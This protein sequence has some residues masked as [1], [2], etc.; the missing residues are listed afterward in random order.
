MVGLMSGGLVALE[1]IASKV[2]QFS[3][4]LHL[5]PVL[6]FLKS[7]LKFQKRLHFSA[8][9]VSNIVIQTS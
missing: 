2:L 1:F 7:N 8:Q 5:N 6:Y 4:F 3:K 9:L